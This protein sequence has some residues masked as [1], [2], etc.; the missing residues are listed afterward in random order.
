MGRWSIPRL[1]STRRVSSATSR[2]G[3]FPLANRRAKRA[4]RVAALAEELIAAG[5]QAPIR[6]DI[7]DEI[8]LKLWGNL[9]F[10]PIS[11]L[12]GATLAG[13]VADAGTRSVARA[14]M[15]EAETVGQALGVRFPVDVDRR[16]AGAGAVGEHKT[17][18]LQDLERGRPLEIDA[19][20]GSVQEVARLIGIPTP[21]IDTIA[22]LLRRLAA[23]RGLA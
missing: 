20:V 15:V 3:A 13:I 5:L 12:T 14:M 16:I 6:T 23:E 7:R 17:S 11:A 1:K 9:S 10:N 4:A 2:A 22:A 21:T 19:L 8:W 18:M